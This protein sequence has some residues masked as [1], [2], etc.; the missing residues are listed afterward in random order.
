MRDPMNTPLNR[1]LA[2]KCLLFLLLSWVSACSPYRVIITGAPPQDAQ[3]TPPEGMGLICILRPHSIGSALTAPVYDNGLL[4]GATKG[5]SY[6]CYAA[7]VGV[8]LVTSHTA[9]TRT[10]AVTV[11][12]GETLYLH[13]ELRIGADRLSV[14]STATAR[15]MLE[16]CDYSLLT[17]APHE[18]IAAEAPATP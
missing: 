4:I 8:H 11:A 13:Q 10:L 17:F 2:P 5:P 7:Q 6:F 9:P 18:D 15:Q 12:G 3:T 16:R 14:V 1:Q